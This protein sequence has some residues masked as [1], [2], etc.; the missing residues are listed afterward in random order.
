MILTGGTIRTMD[1]ERP[2]VEELAIE[3]GRIVE[4]GGGERVDLSGR[5]VLPGFVDA[6]AHFP[7]WALMRRHVRL[8]DC[9]TLEEAVERVGA[10]AAS[11]AGGRLIGYGW[12][13]AG[14]DR[15]PTAADLDAGVGDVPTALWSKDYHTLWVS[16]A[17]GAGTGLL[18]ED[19]AWT[20][21]ERH[22]RVPLD[23][24]VN[25]VLDAI[26]VA[27]ARGVTGIHDKDGRVGAL[28]VWQRVRASGGPPLRV[29]QSLPYERI[30]ELERLPLASGLGDEFL[31]VGY[32]KLF[33]DGTIGSG[34]ATMLRGGGIELTSR[35]GL[36]EAVRRAARAGWPVAVHAIGD[37]ANRDALGAFE[38]TRDEWEPLGLR[39]R[40][41]HAQHLN[42]DDLP[43]FAAL[44]VAVSAQFTHA[45]SD[46][47][48]V[49]RRLPD[50]REVRSYA[51]RALWDSGALIAN[52]SDAP[53]EELD[54][55]AGLVAGVRRTVDDRSPWRPHDALTIE[56]ALEAT[57]VNPAW[58]SRDE[59]RR[60]RLVPGYDADLVVLDRDPFDDL[61]VSV[62]ATMV[63]GRWVHGAGAMGPANGS[64]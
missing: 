20:F 45:T 30:D 28:G 63:A 27:H 19:D 5:C 50:E 36:E 61:S 14:W 42:P 59:A 4:R 38:A 57:T 29:W 32:L 34:T 53:I 54:P 64:A 2:V 18:R 15:E 40:I 7:T 24:Y 47:D 58:L 25:A 16:S 60:G 21:A 8:E 51:F 44:G 62:V 43:R 41:E 13:G 22:L 33:M 26:P 17:A 6:H 11:V 55:L 9:E 39:P 10:A 56:Q 23:E 31:R 49:D 1:P 48:L 37:R 3:G 52:G 12:R 35:A 46:R